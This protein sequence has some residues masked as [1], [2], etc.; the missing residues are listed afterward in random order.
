MDIPKGSR[1]GFLEEQA[2]KL[3][4]Q[5]NY[6]MNRRQSN[7][8]KE[9]QEQR[10][11]TRNKTSVQCKSFGWVDY[12]ARNIQKCWMSRHPAVQLSTSGNK[13]FLGFMGGLM[14]GLVRKKHLGICDT[15]LQ[16]CTSVKN[17]FH[18]LRQRPQ[19]QLRSPQWE[20]AATNKISSPFSSKCA[21]AEEGA[22]ARGPPHSGTDKRAYLPALNPVPRGKMNSPFVIWQMYFTG[23]KVFQSCNDRESS[24]CKYPLGRKQVN[25]LIVTGESHLC[26]W[27]GSRGRKGETGREWELFYCPEL[28]RSITSYLGH[29][30]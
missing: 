9:T 13:C 18:A 4:M 14:T 5:R 16:T 25:K 12:K 23:E 3:K 20:I 6:H 2:L 1:E 21:L 30:G 29:I 15:D 17:R 19:I 22:N 7:E 28:A 10:H 11:S 27:R 26:K 24:R 8:A